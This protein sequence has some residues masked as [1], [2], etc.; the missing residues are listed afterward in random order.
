VGEAG[1]YLYTVLGHCTECGQRGPMYRAHRGLC[2]FCY[3]VVGA[4]KRRGDLR[5]LDDGEERTP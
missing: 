1:G 4:E 2:P 3:H 5:L